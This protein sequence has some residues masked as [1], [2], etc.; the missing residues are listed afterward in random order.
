M[1]R[2]IVCLSPEKFEMREIADAWLKLTAAVKAGTVQPE[3]AQS[4][5]PAR[6]ATRPLPTISLLPSAPVVQPRAHGRGAEDRGEPT[7]CASRAPHEA[8]AQPTGGY[9]R[10]AD[11]FY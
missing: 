4:W 10:R 1:A 6:H 7:A 8:E 9:Q 5:T 2:E 11:P 3:V